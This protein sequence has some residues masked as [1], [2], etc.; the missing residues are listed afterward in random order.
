MGRPFR[1]F[2]MEKQTIL[3]IKEE[4][5]Q[6]WAKYNLAKTNE[7]RLFYELLKQL[8]TIIIEPKSKIGRP[9]VPL[10]DLFFCAGLKLYSNY[11][12]RKAVSDYKLAKQAGY[13]EKQPHF[14]TLKDFLNCDVTYDLLKRLLTIT[15]MPLRNMEDK[16]SLD[17]SGFG[18]YQFERWRRIKEDPRQHR[19]YLKGHILIGT[20]TNIICN[21]EIT[22]G[23]FSDPKQ[24]P[25]IILE[26]NNNFKIK[27]FS[28]DKAYSSKLIFRI[29]ES[30]NV[31]P[32]IPF[33]K[34]TK[35]TDEQDLWGRMYNEFKK[36]QNEWYR[37]YHIRSNVETTFSMIKRRFGEILLSKN[38]VSQ[39][40]ELMMKFICHNIACLIQEIF[41]RKIEIDFSKEAYFLVE[42]KV[43]DEFI[44]RDASKVKNEDY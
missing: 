17:S 18:S 30:I 8:S 27:E 25:K 19:N 44:T 23:N 36:N 14:N 13:I 42:R 37:H 10:K 15:A 1:S 41:E 28:A 29:L 32:Y 6:D 33:R 34:R 21:C 16:Y 9:S 43:P 20:R 24:A 2:K 11:S 40:N 3:P 4:Y 22:P 12:G 39:R 5:K 7:K 31:I 26:A 35:E 38:Y